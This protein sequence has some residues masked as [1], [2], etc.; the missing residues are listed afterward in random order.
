MTRKRA[1]EEGRLIGQVKWVETSRGGG[2]EHMTASVDSL[3]FAFLENQQH[4]L[5][6]Y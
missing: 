4:H 1:G 6:S 2:G 3:S 5:G